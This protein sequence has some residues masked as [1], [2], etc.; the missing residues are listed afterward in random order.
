MRRSASTEK[1]WEVELTAHQDRRSCDVK[2]V[3]V[4]SKPVHELEPIRPSTTTPATRPKTCPR[5]YQ[6]FKDFNCYKGYSTAEIWSVAREQCKRDGADLMV[7]E[8]ERE[9][10]EVFYTMYMKTKPGKT[11]WLGVYKPEDGEFWISVKGE[12]AHS[13]WW[14]SGLPDDIDS[15]RCGCADS[16][17]RL[18]NRPCDD[19]WPYICEFQL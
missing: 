3:D 5:E 12:R 14:R 7:A 13:T 1:Q 10:K 8:S 18:A 15:D 9:R 2:I 6:R 11:H 4:V 17:G 16:T 19:L